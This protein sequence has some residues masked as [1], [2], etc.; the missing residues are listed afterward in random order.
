LKQPWGER[1]TA[2]GRRPALAGIALACAAFVFLLFAFPNYCDRCTYRDV[3]EIL[4]NAPAPTFPAAGSAPSCCGAALA[5]AP[6]VRSS[7][8]DPGDHP[9]GNR[10]P[11]CGHATDS[12]S[13]PS[14]GKDVAHGRVP[15]CIGST[16]STVT[17]QNDLLGEIRR[18][19]APS[20][21][22]TLE[23]AFARLFPILDH[24]DSRASPT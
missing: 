6:A 16:L 19:V 23:T 11:G 1:Y 18:T 10:D 3:A 22:R 2:R 7:C 21:F 13:P 5:K 9:A 17:V 12:K 20:P 8:C 14:D 4:A 24:K 15:Y